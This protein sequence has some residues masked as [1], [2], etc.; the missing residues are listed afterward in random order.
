MIKGARRVLF[1]SLSRLCISAALALSL[2]VGSGCGSAFAF[3]HRHTAFTDELQKYVGMSL[4]DYGSW[5]KSPENLKRYIDSLTAI[6]EVE[7]KSFS[8]DEK[9][10]LWLNAYNALTIYLVLKYYPVKGKKAYY[11]ASSIRQIDGFWEDNK[12][13]IGGKTAT[14]AQIEHNLLR[15]DFRDPRTHFAVVPAAVG[16][17]TI[18]RVAFSAPGLDQWLDR[19]AREYLGSPRNVRVDTKSG[20]IY[21][22]QLF[23]WFPLDFAKSVGLGRAFPPPTDDQIIVAY[24]RKKGGSDL[25]TQIDRVGKKDSEIRVIYEPFDWTLN[26]LCPENPDATKKAARTPALYNF[27]RVLSVEKK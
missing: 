12:I 7:Y 19:K 14:L 9:K 10:A 4:I 17:A 22:P 21:V 6:G 18:E 20:T 23:R 1:S 5:K 3:D 15:R 25:R 27:P 2:F 16:G 26:D 24:L 13:T 11:P 8:E